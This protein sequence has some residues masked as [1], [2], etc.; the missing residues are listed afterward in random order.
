MPAL[1]GR[2]ALQREGWHDATGRERTSCWRVVEHEGTSSLAARER[3]TGPISRR[4]IGECI[5]KDVVDDTTNAGVHRVLERDVLGILG[6]NGARLKEG[7]SALQRRN[8]SLRAIRMR[9]WVGR[10]NAPAGTSKA[11]RQEESRCGPWWC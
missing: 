3:V 7:K 11:G 9:F 2:G 4:P 6:T 8:A 5:A 10:V 1:R